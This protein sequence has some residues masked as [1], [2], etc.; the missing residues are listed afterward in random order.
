MVNQKE[1]LSPGLTR[2]RLATALI[3]VGVLA[4]I[5][6]IMLRVVGQ[7]PSLFLFLPFHLSGVVGGAQLRAAARREMGTAP[8]RKNKLRSIGQILIIGAILVWMPYFYLTLIVQ[9]PVEVNQFLP[10][11]LTG[12]SSGLGL[13]LLNYLRDRRETLKSEQEHV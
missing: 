4:W 13:L 7:K 11:H 9:A 5:P 12:L 3:W 6:F 2:Y 10:Y 1:S 8:P